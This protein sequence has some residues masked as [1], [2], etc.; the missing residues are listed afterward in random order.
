ML[1]V[2]IKDQKHHDPVGGYLKQTPI[3]F[4]NDIEKQLQVDQCDP[5]PEMMNA[6]LYCFGLKVSEILKTERSYEV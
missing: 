6:F 2:T 5:F 1:W 4:K 3:T